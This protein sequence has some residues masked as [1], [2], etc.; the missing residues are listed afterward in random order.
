ME[1]DSCKQE[2]YSL[3]CVSVFAHWEWKHLVHS[4]SDQFA[5]SFDMHER[6]NSIGCMST[7]RRDGPRSSIASFQEEDSQNQIATTTR[8]QVDQEIKL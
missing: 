2:E 7:P 6:D 4:H 8:I 3:A 1:T 5:Y